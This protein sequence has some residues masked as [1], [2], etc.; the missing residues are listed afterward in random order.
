MA[1]HVSLEITLSV[2]FLVW[3]MNRYEV[4]GLSAAE[5][6]RTCNGTWNIASGMVSHLHAYHAIAV[7]SLLANPRPQAWYG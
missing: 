4:G 1:G 7:T 5:Y 6:A 3:V 2:G